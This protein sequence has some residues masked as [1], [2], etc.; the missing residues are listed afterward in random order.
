ME[1]SG[2]RWSIAGAQAV[3]AQRAVVKNGDW[4]DFFTY[5]I[6]AERQRLYPTVYHTDTS[7]LK[8]A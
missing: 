6:D 1:Q 5:Y 3:L 4:N 8:A 7:Y 2:M